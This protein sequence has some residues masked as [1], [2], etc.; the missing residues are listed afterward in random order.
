MTTGT[1]GVA[2]EA[3]EALPGGAAIASFTFLRP[4]DEWLG[5]PDS[6]G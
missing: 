3:R 4:P 6:G 1:A 5:N 2:A